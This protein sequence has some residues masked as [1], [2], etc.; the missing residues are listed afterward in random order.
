M[1]TR[2]NGAVR[3]PAP[4]STRWK[5]LTNCPPTPHSPPQTRAGR[6]P[7]ERIDGFTKG[8]CS[9]PPYATFQRSTYADRRGSPVWI[10]NARTRAKVNVSFG[11]ISGGHPALRRGF[12]LPRKDCRA[13]GSLA[14]RQHHSPSPASVGRGGRGVRACTRVPTTPHAP[15][16]PH[17]PRQPGKSHL[18]RP[19]G[20]ISLEPRPPVAASAMPPLPHRLR[21]ASPTPRER[22]HQPSSPALLPTLAGEGS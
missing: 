6:I 7:R 17:A 20:A 13:K 10:E 22:R 5:L 3:N 11:E 15:H 18:R 9:F 12:I 14:S 1:G 16:T 21:A 19:V 2:A 8:Q 4:E